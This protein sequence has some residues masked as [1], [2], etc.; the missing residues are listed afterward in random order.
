NCGFSP[1]PLDG[2]PAAR[3]HGAF[4]EPELGERWPTLAAFGRDLEAAGLGINVA[5]LVG[6]GAVRLNVVGE[7]DR[8]LDEAALGEMRRPVGE[9]LEDGAFGASSGLIYSPGTFA[10]AA[11]LAALAKIVAR[12]GGFYATHMRDE[13]GGLEAAVEEALEVGRRSGC[14]VQ[15]S[16]LKAMG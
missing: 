4:I 14:A 2:D 13:A 3:R 6:L 12:A 10:D 7:E 11:E 15:I 16:H 9:A 5:P 1:F 8:P